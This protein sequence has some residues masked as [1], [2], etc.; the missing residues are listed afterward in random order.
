MNHALDALLRK[1]KD[2]AVFLQRVK[3][4]QRLWLE[5]RD[6]ELAAQFPIAKGESPQLQYGSMYPMCYANAK[7]ALT[8]Q[9]TEQLEDLLKSGKGC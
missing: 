4:A 7:A 1:Y 2:D 8:R 5:F 3:E 6:A 9:R